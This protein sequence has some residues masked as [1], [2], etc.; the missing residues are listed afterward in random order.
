MNKL[1]IYAIPVSLYCA[2]LRVLLRHK[3]LDWQELLPPGGYGSDEYAQ[4]V[5]SGSLPAMIDGELMLSDSEAIAEYLNEKHPQFPLLP[6]AIELKAKAREL[7]RFH[8]TRLEPEL[9]ALFAHISLGSRDDD[10][11]SKQAS[12]INLRLKELSQLLAVGANKNAAGFQEHLSLGD[13]G[14]AI[15]FTWIKQLSQ[16]MGFHVDWPEAVVDYTA[17]INSF[18]AVAIEL[19]DYQPKLVAWL[20]ATTKVSDL[21]PEMEAES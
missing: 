4:V 7:S 18:P 3:Q 13:C 16:V 10:L 19:E 2:K 15:S 9:R 21:A 14:F 8:D 1:T 5:P 12:K 17:H 6:E 20:E 11:V